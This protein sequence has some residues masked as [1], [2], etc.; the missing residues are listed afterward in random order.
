M[1]R[2]RLYFDV[3]PAWVILF[4]PAIAVA[5]FFLIPRRLRLPVSLVLLV[6]YL[7]VGRLPGAG[8][9]AW[10][11]KATGWA[12]L[13]AVAVAA[14]MHPGPRR[15]LSPV[16][17]LYPVMAAI[18]P[19]YVL[20]TTDWLLALAIRIQWLM[21]VVAAMLVA[22]TIVDAASLMLVVRSIALGGVIAILITLSSFVIAPG[23]AFRAGLNRFAPYDANSNQVGVVFTVAVALALYLGL[24]AS[25]WTRL[26]WLGAA[27][28]ALGQGLLTGSRSVLVTVVGTSLPVVG[29]MARRPIVAIAAVL[30]GTAAMAYVLAQTEETPFERYASLE[31]GRV[32]LFEEYVQRSISERPMFGLLFTEGQSVLRDEELGAHSHNAYLDLAY[33]GGLSL[34]LPMLFLAAVSMYSGVYVWRHRRWLDTDP[35]LITVLVAYLFMAYAHGFVNGSIYYPTYE[36]AFLHLLLSCLF[37]TMAREM[38][39]ALS[40]GVA[41]SAEEGVPAVQLASA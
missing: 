16:L 2:I 12:M 13:A 8:M 40:R 34:L 7:T 29:A 21:M 19:I 10:G 24:R 31:T 27:M 41:V 28:L 20:T 30:V 23:E 3:I 37:V 17:W 36:W 38:R 6:P 4:A 32:Y 35:L 26:F 39:A 22:R 18:A 11:S 9:V 14:A 15:R 33:I 5:V 1:D 25:A